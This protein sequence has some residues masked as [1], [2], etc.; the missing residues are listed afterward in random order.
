MVIDIA[1]GVE[2]RTIKLM[3]VCRLRATPITTFIN[4]MDRWP[5]IT[6][7]TRASRVEARFRPRNSARE[8]RPRGNLH[9]N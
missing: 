9:A 3:E 1:K 5:E 8:C 4:K 2:D 7:N 6:F